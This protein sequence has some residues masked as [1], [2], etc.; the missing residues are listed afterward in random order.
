MEESLLKS[1]YVKAKENSLYGRYISMAHLIP[2]LKKFPVTFQW[3]I[4]GK[5]VLNKPIYAVR[6]GKGAKKVLMWSQM[7]GNES[8][9]TKAVFDLLNALKFSG[10]ADIA[11]LLDSCTLVFIPML[12]P[13]GAEV[14]TREN[15]NGIDLNRDAQALS[16]PES[17]A[18]RKLY[19]YF[20]PDYCF[21]LHGQRTIFSAGKTATPA[22][23][24]FLAPAQ[25]NASSLTK[26]R[27]IA[28]EII[29]EVTKQIQKSIPN[30][31]GIYDDSFNINC[32]GDTFQSLGTP[33]ILVEAGHYKNDY[34]REVTR[35]LV[36]QALLLSLDYI[37]TNSVNGTKYQPYYDIPKNEKLFYDI[38]IHNAS[39]NNEKKDIA[40]QFQ[41]KLVK[42][43]IEFSPKI[44]RIENTLSGYFAHREI[45]A[46]GNPVFTPKNESVFEGY[47][48]DFVMIN[49]EK[50]SLKVT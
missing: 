21:N 41:E 42:G 23:L 5:T 31:V 44:E 28:M 9:T 38:I 48:N 2:L 16:Q 50:I 25:D 30:Q 6:I 40:I 11:S 18:L 33:T 43:K 36:F 34:Q 4:I 19:D 32:V 10:E 46:N 22:T 39:V 15:A 24:S 1:L 13:D 49:N 29:S 26:N 17:I 14:Y 47:E 45:N 7:H 3:E 27:K 12:N 37:T 20:K 8:T 35:E